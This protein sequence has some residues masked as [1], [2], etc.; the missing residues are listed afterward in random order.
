[1]LLAPLTTDASVRLHCVRC[2]GTY[3][4]NENHPSACKIE[5]DDEG[6]SERTE[7]G[8]DAMTTTLTCCGISFDSEEGPDTKYCIMAS[9]TT[10][11]FDVVYY[12]EIDDRDDVDGVNQNVVSCK[13]Q[14]C[15]IKRKAAKKG[16]AKNGSARSEGRCKFA[17]LK[18]DA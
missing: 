3:T 9:H 16:G 17:F 14:G 13:S 11:L 7:V 5:Q 1:M 18:C 4:E 10:N 8:N 15:S 6:E 2:H 12:D